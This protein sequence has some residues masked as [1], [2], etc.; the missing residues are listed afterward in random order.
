MMTICPS[1]QIFP[2]PSAL[3]RWFTRMSVSRG[4]QF[5]L[6]VIHIEKSTRNGVSL[7]LVETYVTKVKV[8]TKAALILRID[9]PQCSVK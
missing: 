7:E 8:D 6:W 2:I 9:H 3:L 1:G 5:P 4:S